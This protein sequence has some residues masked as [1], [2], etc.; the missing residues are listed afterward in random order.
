MNTAA[1][2]VAPTPCL[3]HASSLDCPDT[4]WDCSKRNIVS[5]MTSLEREIMLK[6]T[7]SNLV[8]ESPVIQEHMASY[9][10]VRQVVAEC[11]VTQLQIKA[12]VATDVDETQFNRRKDTA[13]QQMAEIRET[14][15]LYRR[16]NGY[17][18]CC[19]WHLGQEDS[20]DSS[21]CDDMIAM[22]NLQSAHYRVLL[23]VDLLKH[24]NKTQS[25]ESSSTSNDLKERFRADLDKHSDIMS[26]KLSGISSTINDSNA[27]QILAEQHAQMPQSNDDGINC[28]NNAD[29]VIAVYRIFNQEL[30]QRSA[31]LINNYSQQNNFS[32]HMR[33]L[34][35]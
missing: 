10:R 24:L 7:T 16:A 31:K 23:M 27:E 11:M 19:A 35:V 34:A 28:L 3:G 22:G 14:T 5:R 4:T 17:R 2:I 26:K 9:A 6:R 18:A 15:N 8:N 20:F 25:G 33:T 32:F 1:Q 13:D 21:L 30:S 12:G 29:A